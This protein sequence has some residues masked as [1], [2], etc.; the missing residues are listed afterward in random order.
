MDNSTLPSTSLNINAPFLANNSAIRQNCVFFASLCS[1]L[2][3]ATGAVVAKQWLVNYERTGQTGSAET[4]GLRRTEK[5]IGAEA[6]GLS[7][8]VEFLP[9]L[10]LIS[11]ILFFIALVDYLWT[12]N[13]PVALTVMGF[14]V[15]GLLAFNMTVLAAVIDVNCP[16]QTSISTSL[17]MVMTLFIHTAASIFAHLQTLLTIQIDSSMTQSISGRGL[18]HWLLS[19][20]ARALHAARSL[21]TKDL[22]QGKAT[23]AKSEQLAT[24]AIIWMI[25]TASEAEDVY[26]AAE[27]VP[28]IHDL[29]LARLISH[30][31][32]FTIMISRFPDSS[33]FLPLES[34]KD[35]LGLIT[36]VAHVYATNPEHLSKSAKFDSTLWGFPIEDK[37]LRILFAAFQFLLIRPDISTGDE[38]PPRAQDINK[39]LPEFDRISRPIGD[40]SFL[41]IALWGSPIWVVSLVARIPSRSSFFAVVA[42]NIKQ[43]LVRER[44]GETRMA[45]S[46]KEVGELWVAHTGYRFSLQCALRPH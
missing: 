39:E 5:Y 21:A 27:H 9:T 22:R 33:I 16:Y 41:L 25:N 3:A 31:P 19:W 14:S 35:V 20:V 11:L 15:V 13:L 8:V 37:G 2:L 7:P 36:A 24:S 45:R 40:L 1:S 46:E 4:Q 18:Q 30:N 28:T 43:A 26:A 32:A 42:V 12:I 29:E 38:F 44:R 6:W 10:L 17:R 23:L 34:E